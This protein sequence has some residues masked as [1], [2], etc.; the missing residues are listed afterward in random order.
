MSDRHVI[1]GVLNDKKHVILRDLGVNQIAHLILENKTNIT[2]NNKN[3]E[4]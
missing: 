3:V 2:I 4:I 1:N